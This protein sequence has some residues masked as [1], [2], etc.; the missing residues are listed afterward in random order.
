MPMGGVARRAQFINAE[1]GKWAGPLKAGGL[2][3]DQSSLMLPTI[4]RGGSAWPGARGTRAAA[5]PH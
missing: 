2:Q 3:L 4:S 1:A 5:R